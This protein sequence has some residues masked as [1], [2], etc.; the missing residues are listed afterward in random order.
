MMTWEKFGAIDFFFKFHI[1]VPFL[2][3]KTKEEEKNLSPQEV[4]SPASF[5]NVYEHA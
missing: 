1:T 3:S 2:Q 5:G 4:A